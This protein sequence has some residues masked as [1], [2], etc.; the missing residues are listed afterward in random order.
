MDLTTGEPVIDLHGNIKE[1]SVERMFYQIID[2][3]LHTPVLGEPSVPAWGIEIVKILDASRSPI[4]DSI[5]KYLIVN[6]LNPL[7]EPT[8]LSV[9]N[10]SVSRTTTNLQISVE[11]KSEYGTTTKNVV[12]INE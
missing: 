4:W 7:I 10:V 11:V 2:N 3:L 6:A 9:E 8:I 5:I 12:S 1:V